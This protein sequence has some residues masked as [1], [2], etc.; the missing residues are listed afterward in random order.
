VAEAEAEADADADADTEAVTPFK[1]AKLLTDKL[2]RLKLLLLSLVSTQSLF[3]EATRNG[4][5]SFF[6]RRRSRQLLCVN[7]YS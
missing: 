7:Y 3:G 5:S 1:C 6:A 2:C 4:Y